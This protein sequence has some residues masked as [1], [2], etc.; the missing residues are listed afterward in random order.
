[1]KYQTTTERV[2]EIRK[3]LN[4]EFPTFKFSITKRHYN[5]MTIAIMEAPIELSETGYE[6]INEYWI[7]ERYEG[8]KKDILMRIKDIS[9]KGIT[10]R[11]TG[12]Y[13]NQPDFYV[14]IHI[15]KWD[16]NFIC[17]SKNKDF[18]YSPKYISE[19]QQSYSF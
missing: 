3:Q 2:A 18:G 6:Q 7:N 14:N 12:D 15:G 17:T 11:E 1:M 16:K 13:G 5:A 9:F 10:Y 8:A 4:A 19:P